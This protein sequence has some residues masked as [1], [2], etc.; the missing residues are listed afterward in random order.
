MSRPPC[1]MSSVCAVEDQD[2]WTGTEIRFEITALQDG[3][4]E[5]TFQH[6]GLVPEFE[7]YEVCHKSWRFYVGHSLRRLIAEGAGQPNEIAD[8]A[9]ALGPRIDSALSD[10]EGSA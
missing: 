1:P 10:T 6:V 3:G 5:L 9:E 8:T 7:C 4:A 2:E